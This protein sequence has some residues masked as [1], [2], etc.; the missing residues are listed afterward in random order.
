MTPLKQLELLAPARD[1]AT[2][3]EAIL[4][5][6]DAVYIGAQ[7]FGAR[8]KAG[9][10]IAD[11]EQL[12]KFAAPFGVKVYVTVNTIIYDEELGRVERL[13]HQ[14]YAI[15]VD[16]LIVQDMGLL[17]LNL[18]PIALHASTQC[19]TRTPEKAKFLAD[20]GFE[21]IVI[22]RELSL[23]QTAAIAQS[24]DAKIE[25]FVH[26]AICV[27]YNGDCQ[28][29]YVTTGRSANRGECAQMCRLPYDLLDADAN[30][31]KR[32][33]HLL[34]LRDMKRIDSLTEMIEAGVTSFKIEGRLKDIAYVKNV[35][36]AYR[37]ALDEIIAANPDKYSRASRGQS[38][39]SFTPSLDKSFNRRYTEY[40]L[41]DAQPGSMATINT[42][43]SIGEAVGKVKS[44][45]GKAIEI[46]TTVAINNGDGMTYLSAD[47]RVEGFRVNRAKGNLIFPAQKIDIPAGTPLYRNLDKS[48]EERMEQPTARRFIDIALTLR[49][50]GPRRLV[51]EATADGL[52]RVGVS[53]DADISPV[54]KPDNGYRERTLTKLGDTI[55]RATS[56]EDNLDGLFVPASTLSAL[57]RQLT[58]AL[59]ATAMARHIPSRRK[60]AKEEL[61]LPEGVKLSRHDN[62]AN[63]KAEEFYRSC[64]VNGKIAKAI[65]L[66]PI[67][68]R[69]KELRVM[70]TRYC[71]RRE[72]GYCLRK[73]EGKNLK[74]PLYLAGNGFAYRLDFDCRR[75]GMSVVAQDKTILP[76]NILTYINH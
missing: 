26:G 5:G 60:P 61:R 21:Q 3:R 51:L 19:D 46:A 69:D 67:E 27:C 10:S 25:A 20:A 38:D 22:A 76:T 74:G 4:H 13:I 55:Y 23:S 52:G 71:L 15:G 6:A 56:L 29:S 9:N 54:K 49:Q 53:C 58:D 1:L 59:T 41:H 16:A 14:L 70:T 68:Q 43:K 75:C 7:S 18:P 37:L 73:N 65:E 40:F 17:K 30:V 35:T 45:R 62:I 8:S 63:A 50:A 39:I 12:V 33:R 2:A 44:R 28:A 48:W 72:L 34:S 11:I 57:R 64:G 36:A 47:G 66:T 24:T 32:G 31:V 42:P